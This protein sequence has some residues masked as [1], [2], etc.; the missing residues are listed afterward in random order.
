MPTSPKNPSRPKTKTRRIA[1]LGTSLA[2]VGG[3]GANALTLQDTPHQV[4]SVKK[5]ISRGETITEDSLSTVNVKDASPNTIRV[6][7]RGRI[8]GKK[9]DK[10]I[11]AGQ[12]I[13]TQDAQES[14]SL[15]NDQELIGIVLPETNAPSRALKAGDRVMITGTGQNSA[16]A[17][18]PEGGNTPAPQGNQENK[19]RVEGTVDAV[20]TSK[21]GYVK[22]D[23]IVPSGTADA[24]LMDAAVNKKLTVT[25]IGH[26]D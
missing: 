11:S 19:G 9:A 16:G 15:S 23:V 4:I 8:L 22:V 21:E 1:L 12:L 10:D 13:L 26:D 3:L 2:I 20:T 17:A 14:L 5:D 25:L 18:N 6:E 7:D 24:A